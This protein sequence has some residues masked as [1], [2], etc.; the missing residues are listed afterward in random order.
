MNI[1]TI[2]TEI[3]IRL[4]EPSTDE[5]IEQSLCV[6]TAIKRMEIVTAC[7]LRNARHH[8]SIRYRSAVRPK[9]F[10]AA[11]L[12]AQV[13]LVGSDLHWLAKVGAVVPQT[14]ELILIPRPDKLDVSLARQAHQATTYNEVCY[15]SLSVVY[16]PHQANRTFIF[17]H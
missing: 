5:E 7:A 6:A 3:P 1:V 17:T 4:R 2:E 15:L 13:G 11:W 10:W 9:P 16:G 14:K 8:I 12:I